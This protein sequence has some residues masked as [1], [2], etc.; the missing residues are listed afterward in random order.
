[1]C[2]FFYF[3]SSQWQTNKIIHLHCLNQ[4]ACCWIDWLTLSVP[5][6]KYKFL[7]SNMSLFPRVNLLHQQMNTRHKKFGHHE[8]KKEDIHSFFMTMFCVLKKYNQFW[9]NHFLFILATLGVFCV[10]NT[11]FFI[12]SP[13]FRCGI[14]LEY[15]DN[16]EDVEQ[17]IFRSLRM[18]G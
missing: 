4:T 9:N 6:H 8:P 10:P 16:T 3:Q 14:F 12:V 7:Y 18:H 15:N 1:M 11:Y 17:Q 5:L 2:P 13:F